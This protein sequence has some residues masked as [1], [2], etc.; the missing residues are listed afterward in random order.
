M[1]KKDKSA[2]KYQN[3]LKKFPKERPTLSQEYKDIYDQHYITNR[4]GWVGPRNTSNRR[5]ARKNYVTLI[6]SKACKLR[7]YIFHNK[8][9]LI[10]P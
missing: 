1:I 4:G 9:F 6:A 3:L 10:L 7:I 5:K 8:K 2:E